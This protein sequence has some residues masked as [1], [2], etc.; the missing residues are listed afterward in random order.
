MDMKRVIL[1]TGV[2]FQKKPIELY[3]L[4][5]IV[6]PDYVPDFSKFCMRFCDPIKSK[7]AKEGFDFSG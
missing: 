2:E 1:L 6:R 7:I 4:M 3:N 5:K